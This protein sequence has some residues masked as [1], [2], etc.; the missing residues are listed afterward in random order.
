[1]THTYNKLNY[2]QITRV[3][4][5]TD[6]QTRVI[7]MQNFHFFSEIIT[8]VCLHTQDKIKKNH[9][10]DRTHK[11]F[12]DCKISTVRNLTYNINFK[13]ITITVK[14]FHRTSYRQTNIILVKFNSASFA[15]DVL[16]RPL[17]RN[18][19][20]YI[21]FLATKQFSNQIL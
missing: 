18:S 5:Q 4:V 2:K 13:N 15:F 17:A 20:F 12:I 21:T 11:P 14:V 3:T 10:F 1:M 7:C 19:L 8:V 6:R 9:A 16:R